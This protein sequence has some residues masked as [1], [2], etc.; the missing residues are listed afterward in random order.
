MAFALIDKCVIQAISTIQLQDVHGPTLG[1]VNLK[2]RKTHGCFVLKI[3]TERK[4]LS[5][6][7][8]L[9]SPNL[10]SQLNDNVNLKTTPGTKFQPS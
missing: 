8:R 5:S 1:G 9:T 4:T 3:T 10:M 2:F 7:G 6:S